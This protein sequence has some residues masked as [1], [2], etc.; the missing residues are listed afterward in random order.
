[1]GRLLKSLLGVPDDVVRTD[2]PQRP[3]IWEELCGWYALPG[4][5]TLTDV[6]VRGFF[7]AG[8]EVMARRG[9]LLLRVLTPVPVLYRGFPLRPDDEEDPYVF[10]ID[11]SEY[12][13]AASWSRSA[14]SPTRGPWL[15]TSR[16]RCHGRPSSNPRPPTRGCGPR[17][18]SASPPRRSSVA[19]FC[20]A[21]A[22]GPDRPAPPLRASVGDLGP[23]S[24]G[25]CAV[26]SWICQH[27]TV[28]HRE[29]SDMSVLVAY[30]SKRGLE[31]R[32]ASGHMRR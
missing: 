15:S 11:L 21:G 5:L 23:L 20:D 4:P 2:I 12:R 31:F 3:E 27:S 17:A 18:R 29:V 25:A 9:E 26:A 13:M 24:G 8:I 10:R 30:A 6:R 19:G 28:D 32:T 1:M 7:G 16:R 22:A 14:A